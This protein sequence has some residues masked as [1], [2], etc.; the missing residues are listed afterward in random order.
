MFFRR[1][2]R[3]QNQQRQ[4]MATDA[5]ELKAPGSSHSSLNKLNSSN[6]S[7]NRSADKLL[8]TNHTT[9]DLIDDAG[10]INDANDNDLIDES[11]SFLQADR[12]DKNANNKG[13][14]TATLARAETIEEDNVNSPIK[15]KNP[16]SNSKKS[17]LSSSSSNDTSHNNSH[18]HH[19]QYI[20]YSS[21]QQIAPTSG[22]GDSK[23]Q[24]QSCSCSM[25]CRMLAKKSPILI[26][27]LI[28]SCMAAIYCIPFVDVQ[29]RVP[30]RL[31]NIPFNYR[32]GPLK[33]SDPSQFKAEHLFQNQ[34]HGAESIAL[35]SLGN[36][37]MAIEGG[38]IL[39]AHLNASSTP[40]KAFSA[41]YQALTNPI[42]PES[43]STNSNKL[44]QQTDTN[45]N[46]KLFNDASATLNQYLISARSFQLGNLVNPRL[47]KIA[48][49]NPIKQISLEQ[50][51][52][53]GIESSSYESTWRREC[54]LDEQVYGRHLWTN[55]NPNP[56]QEASGSTDSS[57]SQ[58]QPQTQTSQE[59]DI[60]AQA[61]IDQNK[62][63]YLHRQ[64]KFY[65]RV[66]MSRCSKPLGIR[67]SP[68]ENYLYVIDTLT[69]FYKIHLRV[70]ERPNSSQK[71]VTK[72]I[73]FKHQKHHL[74]P[75]TFLDL[76]AGHVAK[77]VSSQLTLA[78]NAPTNVY[79]YPPS[80]SPLLKQKSMPQQQ[81]QQRQKRIARQTNANNLNYYST[82]DL[83]L[84][85]EIH[86]PAMK[87][88]AYLNTSL[89]AVDD[90]VIDYGAGTRGGD[91]VYLSVASQKWIAVS[92]VY[93]YLE[94]RPTG[95]ILRF[96]TGAN[97]LSVLS[98]HQISHVRT[99]MSGKQLYNEDQTL[100]QWFDEDENSIDNN[101]FYHLNSLNHNDQQLQPP[102]NQPPSMT[103]TT[104]TTST[105]TSTMATYVDR[106]GHNDTLWDTINYEP[107]GAPRLDEND[108]FD[109]RPLHFPNGLELTDD[110][111]ALLIADTANK[112][113]IKHFIRGPRK[114]TSDLWAWTPNF[115]D[116][117][118][119]G[120]EKKRETYWVVGCG[121]DTTDKI[122]L[123]DWLHSWP[124]MRKYIVKN[125][126]LF[127]WFLE[128]IGSNLIRST[129]IRDLGFA[130]RTGHMLCESMCTG[131]MILQYD[132]NGKL[133]R[134]IYGRDFP[135]DVAYYSQV[136]EV[137]DGQTNQHY[138]YLA[139]PGYNYVTKLHLPQQ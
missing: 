53:E 108:I 86:A 103:M 46:Q 102:V 47:F 78:D 130:I 29:P 106:S 107:F 27:L 116:N 133:I 122:D 96:D 89:M 105:S 43:V 119:R 12:N 118:R 30:K 59:N 45:N 21:K 109:D 117:I 114:G 134:S 11:E 58:P 51:R 39:Y 138:L 4:Q 66:K 60:T 37:F 112:R 52:R 100:Y 68:D 113:I 22:G 38:F 6:G 62:Q 126:Y 1:N 54:Q 139:S 15:T 26:P 83:M 72:L 44:L 70:N 88:R 110:K 49:L 3:Q 36:M 2:K 128:T 132:A 80:S 79:S 131:M 85:G 61:S 135:P 56:D 91:M 7:N 13:N 129:R 8:N 115:P 90:L 98:P 124:R 84:D 93:D 64:P 17:K 32:D 101:N 16:L 20:N 25:F 120:Y 121:E 48:E 97:Q 5:E 71:L 34:I 69:G 63:N 95:A 87:V 35:D 57:T 14:K 33:P 125:M 94:G 10:L 18:H 19:S 28:L 104:T 40:N 77:P 74:L 24:Q 137:I 41:A 23:Q 9:I 123:M 111:Q 81:Q 99:S 136:N 75:V 82:G 73:D 92:F 76:A 127:G 65:S 55:Q 42:L 50:R 31:P 67:L